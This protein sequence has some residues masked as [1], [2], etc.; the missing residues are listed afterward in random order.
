MLD[1]VEISAF[2]PVV[3]EALTNGADT[4]LEF[5]D[6]VGAGADGCR[7]VLGAFCR[8]LKWKVPSAIGRSAFGEDR[9]A[10]TS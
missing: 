4:G 2:A 8:I 9:M 3:A 6:L 1:L 7:E 10:F 5:L